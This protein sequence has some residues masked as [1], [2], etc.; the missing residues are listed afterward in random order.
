MDKCMFQNWK[1]LDNLGTSYDVENINWGADGIS[2]TLISYDK[3]PEKDYVH[4]FRLI[5]ASNSIISYHVTDETY[6]ADC[7]DLDVKNNGRFYTSTNSDYIANLR[8][9]SH[10]FPDNAIH[11]LIVGTDTIID[12]IAKDYPIVDEE[13]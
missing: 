6:R 12:I 5:W 4:R 9:K 7:W 1:P 13:N 11:F 2:F 8:Q 10:L 3:S